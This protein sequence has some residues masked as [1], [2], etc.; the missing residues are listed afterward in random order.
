[1]PDLIRAFM[2]VQRGLPGQAPHLA[3]VQQ[4][5]LPSPRSL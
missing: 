5:P 1:M 4:C 3:A 2:I